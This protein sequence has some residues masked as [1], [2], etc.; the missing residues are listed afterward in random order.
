MLHIYDISRLRLK[1]RVKFGA[2]AQILTDQVSNFLSDRFQNTC[3]LLKVKKILITAF[4]PES[5]GSLERSHRVLAEYLSHYVRED[6][7]NWNEWIPYAV[8]VYKTTVHTTTV[9]TPF[10]SVYGFRSEVPPALRETP[11]VQHN[12]ENY[13]TELRER[14]QS[15]HEVARHKMISSKEKIRIII[16]RVLKRLKFRWGRKYCFLMRLY[17]GED[18]RN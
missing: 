12:Y 5:N 16:I 18:L 10:E 8:Y 17:V 11:N 3:K 13:S 1:H 2:P 9:Y 6:Q 15:A 7:T 14:L 4:H